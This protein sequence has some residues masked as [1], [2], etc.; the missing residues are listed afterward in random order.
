MLHRMFMFNDSHNIDRYL[1][2]IEASGCLNA[3][4]IWAHNPK[5]F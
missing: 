2:Y 4:F 1:S 5:K 3:N